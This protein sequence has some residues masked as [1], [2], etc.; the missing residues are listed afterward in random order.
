MELNIEKKKDLLQEKFWTPSSI[1]SKQ[2]KKQTS[3][4]INKETKKL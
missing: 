4:Q 3:K 1:G 2:K